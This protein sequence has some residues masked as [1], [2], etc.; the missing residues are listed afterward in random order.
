M[1][2]QKTKYVVRISRTK[3]SHTHYAHCNCDIDTV[4]EV[5]NERNYPH[6]QY[7]TIFRRNGGRNVRLFEM[8]RGDIVFDSNELEFIDRK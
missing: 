3:Y 4:E 8:Y 2:K 6:G 7:V 5:Y 1:A